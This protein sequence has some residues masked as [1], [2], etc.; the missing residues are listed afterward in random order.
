MFE[1]LINIVNAILA[2]PTQIFFLYWLPLII[3]AIGYTQKT[4]KQIKE[5]ADRR[6]KS[7]KVYFPTVTVGTILGR[8]FLTLCPIVNL[9]NA[10]WSHAFRIVAEVIGWLEKVFNQPLVPPHKDP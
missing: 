8:T 10:T 9:W 6:S 7:P 2:S 1:W 3:C 5:D 4:F